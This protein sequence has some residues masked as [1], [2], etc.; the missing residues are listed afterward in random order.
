[1]EARV[2]ADQIKGLIELGEFI[3]NFEIPIIE[4]VT[5]FWMIRSKGGYFYNEFVNSGF[6]ALAWNYLDQKTVFTGDNLE[7]LKDGVKERYG[8]KVPQTAINKCERFINDIQKGDFVVIPNKG[9][10]EITIGKLGEYYEEDYSDTREIVC[11][12]KIENSEY[13]IGD[14]SCPYKKRRKLN[15]LLRVSSN[16]VGYIS[17]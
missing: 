15:V 7:I 16:R 1:M 14:V 3:N 9:S 8:D 2:R 4:N 13:E 6:V 5:K 11:I 10:D 17:C 12:K